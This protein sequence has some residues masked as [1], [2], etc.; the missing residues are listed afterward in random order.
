MFNPES[1]IDVTEEEQPVN[2]LQMNKAMTR[3]ERIL[4]WLIHIFYKAYYRTLRIEVINPWWENPAIKADRPLLIAHW[5]EDDMALIGRYAEKGIHVIVSLSKDGDLLNYVLQKQGWNPI[6]GSSSRGGAKALLTTVKTLQK[7]SGVCAVTI[8]GP[9]GPRHRAKPGVAML[10]QKAKA[11]IIT[12]SAAAK[13]RFVFTKSWSQT[14]LPLPFSRVVHFADPMPLEIAVDSSETDRQ[15]MLVQIENRL[16]EN[17]KKLMGEV[18][19]KK[20]K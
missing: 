16:I 9:R 4:A 3:K 5:H 18:R 2:L 11:Q 19:R 14:Y 6:R 12:L 13:H 8:D 10:A 1:E 15:G 7:T 20:V 17:H